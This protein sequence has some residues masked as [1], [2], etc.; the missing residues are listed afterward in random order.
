M[1][2]GWREVAPAVPIATPFWAGSSGGLTWCTDNKPFFDVRQMRAA[3]NRRAKP[4]L[5]QNQD[6][7]VGCFSSLGWP[8]FLTAHLGL[9]VR[10]CTGLASAVELQGKLACEVT[11]LKT[12][13]AQPARMGYFRIMISLLRRCWGRTRKGSFGAGCKT[14]EGL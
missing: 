4:R 5:C 3:Q 8:S 6:T 10:P 13:A 11:I 14:A 9:V 7:A 12:I 2:V 1:E